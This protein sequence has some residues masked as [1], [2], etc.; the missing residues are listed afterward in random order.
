MAQV[1]FMRGNKETL[2]SDIVDGNVNLCLDSKEFFVDYADDNGTLYRI[3]FNTSETW[4]F[5]L[6]DGSTVTKNVVVK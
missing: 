5:T 6:A 3:P 1:K 2:P 4:T